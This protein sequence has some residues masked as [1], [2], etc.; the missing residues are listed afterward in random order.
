MRLLGRRAWWA[1]S[2][3]V[4]FTRRAGFSHVDTDYE[5]DTPDYGI[6]NAPAGPGRLAAPTSEPAAG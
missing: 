5:C 6:D 3:I 2:W 1:P 4:G